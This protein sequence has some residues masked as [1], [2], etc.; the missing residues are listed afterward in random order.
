MKISTPID[1]L[2]LRE[3]AYPKTGDQLDAIIKALAYLKAQG[4]D[5]GPDGDGLVAGVDK[6]KSPYKKKKQ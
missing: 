3:K 5:I 4:I 1:P 2:H 6:I